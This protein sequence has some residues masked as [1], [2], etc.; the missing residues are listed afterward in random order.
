MVYTTYN[1]W[2]ISF[3]SK[4]VNLVSS[5]D[6]WGGGVVNF[7]AL[8]VL[9][10]NWFWILLF[11]VCCSVYILCE[12]ILLEYNKRIIV[13]DFDIPP[14]PAKST[15]IQLSDLTHY[16]Q[17][18]VRLAPANPSIAYGCTWHFQRALGLGE[19][20]EPTMWRT[21]LDIL[22]CE[23]LKCDSWLCAQ[24]SMTPPQTNLQTWTVYLPMYSFK[25]SVLAATWNSGWD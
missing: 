6:H 14:T 22:A 9:H 5:L 10:C 21:L 12:G 4:S 18:C 24:V 23:P 3:G 1:Y 20:L 2:S 19:R 15:G 8:R 25:Y 13:R 16:P 7:F 17:A 11:E